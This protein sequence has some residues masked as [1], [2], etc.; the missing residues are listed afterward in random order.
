M[1]GLSE[2]FDEYERSEKPFKMQVKPFRSLK[3]PLGFGTSKTF[4]FQVGRMFSIS[5][6]IYTEFGRNWSRDFKHT[7]KKKFDQPTIIISDN[8]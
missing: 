4:L 3:A 1:S 5:W 6:R 8:K 7:L 2:A